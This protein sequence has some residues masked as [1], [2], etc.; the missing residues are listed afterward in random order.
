MSA[1][2]VATISVVRRCAKAAGRRRWIQIDGGR[3][4]GEVERDI[5]EPEQGGRAGDRRG[6]RLDVALDEDAE[7]P[8]ERH[9]VAGVCARRSPVLAAEA[10]DELVQGVERE[11]GQQ[12]DAAGVGAGCGAKD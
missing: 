11:E 12:L 5:E 6:G 9:D 10:A 7:V 3:G 4:A 2:A 8:L 1:S